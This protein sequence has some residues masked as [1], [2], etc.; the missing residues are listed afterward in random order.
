MGLPRGHGRPHSF[1]ARR[2]Y[3][4][5]AATGAPVSHALGG[6]HQ[7]PALTVMGG[8]GWRLEACCWGTC[9]VCLDRGN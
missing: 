9:G 8:G 6:L 4:N 1:G 5:R 2:L 3:G 7:A